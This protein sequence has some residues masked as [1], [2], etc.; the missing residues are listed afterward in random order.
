MGGGV[1]LGTLGVT[2]G[3]GPEPAKPSPPSPSPTASAQ[4]ADEREAF[5]E[6]NRQMMR[7]WTAQQAY[8]TEQRLVQEQHERARTELDKTLRAQAEQ[9]RLRA[10]DLIYRF[11]PAN[12]WVPP[13]YQRWSTSGTAPPATEA[14]AAKPFGGVRLV[15]ESVD[16][17]PIDSAQAHVVEDSPTSAMP[18]DYAILPIGDAAAIEAVK[19]GTLEVRADPRGGISAVLETRDGQRFYYG[20]IG[21]LPKR[22]VLAGETIGFT[23]TAPAERG[24]PFAGGVSPLP[25]PGAMP[26]AAT[27]AGQLP[28]MREVSSWGSAKQRAPEYAWKRPAVQ[29]T[30]ARTMSTASGDGSPPDNVVHL[31]TRGDPM[32]SRPGR[33][34]APLLLVGLGV[35]L[36]AGGKKRR[37]R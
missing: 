33:S 18:A 1:G 28:A 19:D 16:Q 32:P 25:T 15:N 3:L 30:A 27:P 21:S 23:S 8:W 13:Q 7:D 36:L 20:H 34:I 35:A 14:A 9:E 4:H 24:S 2:H 17:P 29:S 11:R 6:R 26:A 37:R 31:P 5:W 22:P 12:D 10:S